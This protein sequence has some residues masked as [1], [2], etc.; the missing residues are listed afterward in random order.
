MFATGQD[1]SGHPFR[2][3]VARWV[4]AGLGKRR[5]RCHPRQSSTQRLPPGRDR[6]RRSPPSASRASRCGAPNLDEPAVLVAAKRSPAPRAF[7]CQ[8]RSWSPRASRSNAS[9]K[10]SRVMIRGL[11]K[12]PWRSATVTPIMQRT[13]GD[14]PWHRLNATLL[15][16]TVANVASPVEAKC[17]VRPNRPF[18][19]PAATPT[20]HGRRAARQSSQATV[21]LPRASIMA[22][23]RVARLSAYWPRRAG[24]RSSAVARSGP[25]RVGGWDYRAGSR[26]LRDPCRQ[27][28]SACRRW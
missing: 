5:P 24:G 23:P 14:S 2:G 1:D 9:M 28:L 6:R 8:T 19:L 12:W 11:P 15:S 20:V 21:T 22:G 7:G 27:R 13:A 3:R 4:S 26:A 25:R 17:C 16:P 10:P 18:T